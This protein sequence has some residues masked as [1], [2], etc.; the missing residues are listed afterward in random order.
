[1]NTTNRQWANDIFFDDMSEDCG[2]RGLP[3]RTFCFATRG[4]YYTAVEA[5]S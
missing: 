2:D 5:V 1:M 4:A 3:S